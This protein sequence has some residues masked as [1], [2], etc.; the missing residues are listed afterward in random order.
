MFFVCRAG[1]ESVEVVA[2]HTGLPKEK[3]PHCP[4]SDNLIIP[5]PSTEEG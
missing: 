1:L 4:L 5:S 2:G 3:S